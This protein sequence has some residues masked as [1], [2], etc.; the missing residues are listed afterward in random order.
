MVLASK[1]CLIRIRKLREATN[2]D[3]L[4]VESFFCI[5]IFLIVFFFIGA[6]YLFLHHFFVGQ[7]Q[8]FTA[9]VKNEYH[10]VKIT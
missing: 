6:M 5:V 9:F 2:R 7:R 4:T 3:I 10:Q 1:L 8:E